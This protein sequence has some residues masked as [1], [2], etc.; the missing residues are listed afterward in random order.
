MRHLGG[1]S[2]M[3]NGT[4]VSEILSKFEN[5]LTESYVDK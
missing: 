5:G 3:K 1:Q 2:Y 4:G